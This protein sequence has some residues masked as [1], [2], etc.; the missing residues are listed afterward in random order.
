MR[1]PIP[2]QTPGQAR[3]PRSLGASVCRVVA[4]CVAALLTAWLTPVAGQQLLDRIVAAVGR[5][6]IMLSDVQIAI[7]L[8]VVTPVTGEEPIASAT[9]Q[10]VDR[11]LMLMEVARFLP[12]APDVGA[13]KAEMAALNA[14]AGA[15]L[16]ALMES[17]GLD[18]A[19]LERLA[20]ETLLIQAYLAQRF[21][22]PLPASEADARQYYDAHRDEF[23]RD[24]VARPFDEVAPVARE[25]AT[26]ERRRA[27]IAAWLASLR[28]RA[29]ITIRAPS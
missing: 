12:P 26:D 20:R 7:A 19:R 17:T 9:Q 29:E 15:G 5:Q 11:Q 28:K 8:K 24:G 27:T 10:M 4:V 2:T 21:G 13:V 1:V 25:R 3:F 22:A 16:P 6:P 18:A 14:R 23:A